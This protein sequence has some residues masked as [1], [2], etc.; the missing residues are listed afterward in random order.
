MTP[1]EIINRRT[2][3]GE[4]FRINQYT[5]QML[6]TLLNKISIL[7]LE[8][9]FFDKGADQMRPLNLKQFTQCFLNC[10]KY[11]QEDLIYLTSGI[12]DLFEDI[13][14]SYNEEGHKS[15]NFSA[16][17]FD[18]EA[19]ELLADLKAKN[20][21]LTKALDTGKKLRWTDLTSYM[22]DNVIAIQPHEE[23]IKNRF[24]SQA[25]SEKFQTVYTS[26]ELFKY[27]P[28]V[29]GGNSDC[30]RTIEHDIEIQDSCTREAGQK[31]YLPDQKQ[32]CCLSHE[33][34]ALSLYDLNSDYVKTIHLDQEK[35]S[36][37]VKIL[38]F[39]Y[40]E[41]EQRIGAIMRDCTMGFWDMQY[42]KFEKVIELPI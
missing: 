17:N 14:S 23:A 30:L 5:P 1:K 6:L 11:K 28:E 22:I 19:K 8:Q 3:D 4:E 9:N 31:M 38:D 25:T 15:N 41:T 18:P 34:K 16:V 33:E 37:S 35:H 36:D 2:A 10:V 29:R 40:S 24:I 7:E 42:D 26:D 12:K 32:I 27:L 20:E 13:V 21:T 39:T